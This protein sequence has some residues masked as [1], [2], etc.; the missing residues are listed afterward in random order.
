MTSIVKKLLNKIFP[1]EINNKK[2]FAKECMDEWI[3]KGKQN[4]PPHIVKQLIIKEVRDTSGYKILIETGTYLGDMIEAQ[5]KNFDKIYSVELGEKL[6]KDAVEKFEKDKNVTILNGDSGNVLIDLMTK[7]EQPAIFW[8]DGHYSAG[9][10][11]M[12]HKFCPIYEELSAIFKNQPF[13]HVLLIDDARLFIGENDYPTLNELT[14]FIKKHRP[15][16]HIFI[17]H[18]IIH[19]YIN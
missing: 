10:T 14:E 7:I 9:I 8:L 11:A 6:Y 17:K 12:G 13:N 18:D 1:T 19:A 5:K 3:T 16:T 2:L 4:P 15:S